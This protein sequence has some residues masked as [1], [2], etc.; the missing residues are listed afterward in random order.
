M[1]ARPRS[2]DEQ[3]ATNPSKKATRRSAPHGRVLPKKGVL[4]EGVPRRRTAAVRRASGRH[5]RHARQQCGSGRANSSMHAPTATKMVRSARQEVACRLP[6]SRIAGRKHAAAE[7]TQMKGAALDMLD[8]K[9]YR[10]T[11]GSYGREAVQQFTSSRRRKTT[12]G[13]LVRH[14]QGGHSQEESHRL[15][16]KRRYTPT[17]STKEPSDGRTDDRRG[18][19]TAI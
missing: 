19:Q 17:S 15:S 5:V 8:N 11:C 1:A 2:S 14:V 10:A 18:P 7:A 4:A 3:C 12:R 13:N 16:G 9:T 6:H